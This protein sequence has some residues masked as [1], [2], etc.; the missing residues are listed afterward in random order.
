MKLE[1]QL[2]MGLQGLDALTVGDGEGG[3]GAH[4]DVDQDTVRGQSVAAGGCVSWERGVVLEEDFGISVGHR[5]PSRFYCHE[6][7]HLGGHGLRRR[8]AHERYV[9]G[10]DAVIELLSSGGPCVA[11][12]EVDD[13]RR[14]LGLSVLVRR[15]SRGGGAFVDG[16]LEHQLVISLL[17]VAGQS[18]EGVRQVILAGQVEEAQHFF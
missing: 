3:C 2:E 1:A 7:L 12:E 11:P 10:G 14:Q 18:S 17:L 9:E 5:R 8:L 4:H 15:R 13:V 16:H 6:A